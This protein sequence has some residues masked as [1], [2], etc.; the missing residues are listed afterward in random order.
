MQI[1]AEVS[2]AAANHNI[3]SRKQKE[4]VLKGREKVDLSN[5]KVNTPAIK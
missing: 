2:L 5:V 4:W 1:G 3:C